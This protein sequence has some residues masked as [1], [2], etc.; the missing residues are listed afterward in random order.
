MLTIAQ[1]TIVIHAAPLILIQNPEGYADIRSDKEFARQYDNSFHLIVPNE[2]FANAYRIRI[3]QR[4]ICKQKTGNAVQ[5]LQMRQHMQNPCIVGVALRR[6]TIVR[7]ARIIRQIGIK[8]PFQIER[9]I[10]HDVVEIQALVQIMRKRGIIRFT[11]IMADSAKCQ[12]HLRKAIGCSILFLPIDID[13]AN[14]ASLGPDKFRALYKHAAGTAAGII[15][16]AVK[17]LN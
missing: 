15:Q 3:A 12:V 1:H 9:R 4:A 11:K 6:R 14:I 7:P 5:R 10:G 2:L 13:A 16:S 8:P 17:R